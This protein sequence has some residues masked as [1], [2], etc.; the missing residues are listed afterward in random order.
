MIYAI[1]TILGLVLIVVAF[2]SCL[3]KNKSQSKQNLT[4]EKSLR[5]APK[6][7]TGAGDYFDAVNKAQ[8]GVLGV[9]TSIIPDDPD[10][11]DGAVI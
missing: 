11:T 8:G 7:V 6:N 3:G 5:N 1:L 10:D 4:D 2:Y 9:Q